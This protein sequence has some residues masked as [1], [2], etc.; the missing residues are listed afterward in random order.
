MPQVALA[1][2]RSPLTVPESAPGDVFAPSPPMEAGN[3]S[4]LELLRGF[5]APHAASRQDGSAAALDAYAIALGADVFFGAGA[6]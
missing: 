3:A 5:L 4:V 1:H 6:G 2:R